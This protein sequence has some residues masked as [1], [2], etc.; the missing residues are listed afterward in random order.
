MSYTSRSNTW[1]L[2]GKT[3]SSLILPFSR[4]AEVDFLIA[5]ATKARRDLGWE[6]QC[7]FEKMIQGM[8]DADLERV[9]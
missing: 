9:S 7:T 4:P 3:T 2:P 6:P 1:A 8:V 5:D